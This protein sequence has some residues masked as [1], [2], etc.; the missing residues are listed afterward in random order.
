MLFEEVTIKS[1]LPA[2]VCALLPLNREKIVTAKL[3][4]TVV[5]CGC[6]LSRSLLF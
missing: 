5:C 4:L 2:F 6:V 3:L 1:L